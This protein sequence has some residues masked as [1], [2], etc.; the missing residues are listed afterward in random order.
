MRLTRI[1][2]NDPL[3]RVS[4]RK[5]LSSFVVAGTSLQG[6]LFWLELARVKDTLT[7]H[8]HPTAPSIV[9]S[10]RNSPRL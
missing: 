2:K 9:Y 1:I 7:Q 5:V 10:C 4:A 6:L 3:G 8:I